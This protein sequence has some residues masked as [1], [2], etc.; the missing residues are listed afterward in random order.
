MSHNPPFFSVLIP[1]YN[2]AQFLGAALDSLLNQTFS[3]WEGIII[4][5]GST[6]D[7]KAIIDAYCHKDK[8]FR[9][10][11]KENG[12]TGSALN[13]GLSMAWGEWI[14]WLSSDDLFESY[15]LITHFQWIQKEPDCSFFFTHFRDLDDKSGKIIDSEHWHPLPDKPFQIIEM[16]RGN[17][18]SGNSVCINRIA[19]KKVGLFNESL[20]YGQDYDMWLRLMV[21][22]PASYLPVRTCI[23]RQH[24]HQDGK[25]FPQAMYYDSAKAAI[26]FLNIHTLSNIFPLIDLNDPKL[27]WNMLSQALNVAE[28][29]RA[30][31]YALGAHPL[32]VLRVLEWVCLNSAIIEQNIHQQIVNRM[33]TFSY[34]N[35]YKDFSFIWN[36]SSVIASLDISIKIDSTE[37]V[38]IA[39]AY[40]R[41]RHVF[42]S[43]PHEKVVL[44]RWLEKFEEL[45]LEEITATSINTPKDIL[46]VVQSQDN[47]LDINEN[48]IFDRIFEFAKTLQLFGNN[49]LLLVYGVNDSFLLVYQS[50]VIMVSLPNNSELNRLLPEFGVFDIAVILGENKGLNFSCLYQQQ[51]TISKALDNVEDKALRIFDTKTSYTHL[52]ASWLCG[53][54]IHLSK[55][56][57]LIRNDSLVISFIPLLLYHIV[58]HSVVII[59]RKI[60]SGFH[61]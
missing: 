55:I 49:V 16:L 19:W 25:R 28:D 12:G 15:K 17:F 14:C 40:Y 3:N 13:V 51:L 24:L 32:L 39:E 44:R 46:L 30:F 52:F 54:Y 9:T 38:N 60:Q 48:A 26:Q 7:T 50:N 31:I 34:L 61:V 33:L 37:P 23:S 8:R 53:S 4:N 6:D 41:R 35:R 18:V 45:Q 47:K 10:F 27:T 58:R 1:T 36:I 57:R 2:Q 42:R 5:D 29:K 11:H 59:Y 22:Y 43:Q 56:I 20:R 21:I